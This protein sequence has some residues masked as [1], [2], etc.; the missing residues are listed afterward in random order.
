MSDPPSLPP[1]V[2]REP[3]MTGIRKAHGAERLQ[4]Q[5]IGMGWY[6]WQL[7]VVVG[8]GT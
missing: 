3:P 2:V 1:A 5:D 7:F 8:F 6:Q 4:I